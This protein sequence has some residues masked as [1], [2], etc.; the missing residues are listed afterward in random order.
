MDVIQGI[1]FP[2]LRVRLGRSKITR[3]P[4][5][6]GN[7]DVQPSRNESCD[8]SIPKKGYDWFAG[9]PR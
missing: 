8:I 7:F 1:P 6:A 5:Q 2:G 3:N 4:A 9:I